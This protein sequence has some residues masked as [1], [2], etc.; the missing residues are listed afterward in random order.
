[1][2]IHGNAYINYFAE[3]PSKL[4]NLRLSKLKD[5]FSN[6]SRGLSKTAFLLEKRA[7]KS[8]V[9]ILEHIRFETFSKRVRSLEL[10]IKRWRK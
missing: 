7:M 10:K 3:I 6:Q 4:L 2:P 8:P 1:L 9:L 5:V